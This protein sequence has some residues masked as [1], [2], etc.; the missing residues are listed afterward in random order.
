M[1]RDT[2]NRS[3]TAIAKHTIPALKKIGFGPK[4]AKAKS[5]VA[6]ITQRKTPST[7]VQRKIC[8]ATTPILRQMP[9]SEC[10]NSK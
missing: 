8:D 3:Q 4:S 9:I 6:E 7:A 5:L 1:L 10:S 2:F